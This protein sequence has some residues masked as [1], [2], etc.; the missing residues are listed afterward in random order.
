M[1]RIHVCFAVLLAS[2]DPRTSW[3]F[4]SF[5]QY[6]PFSLQVPSPFRYSFTSCA[7]L[8]V[9]GAFSFI[10]PHFRL[11]RVQ[12]WS[13]WWWL[14]T[15]AVPKVKWRSIGENVEK[16]RNSTKLKKLTHLQAW[17]IMTS[18]N[19]LNVIMSFYF[20]FYRQVSGVGRQKGNTLLIF[21]SSQLKPVLLAFQ[22]AGICVTA[23][24]FNHCSARKQVR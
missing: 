11:S 14:C 22:P 20:S 3:S 21:L 24:L 7:S 4:S 5:A 15:R 13:I 10:I 9:R 17:I 19:F 23:T 18:P 12:A 6:I 2:D 1:G 8:E 16:Y